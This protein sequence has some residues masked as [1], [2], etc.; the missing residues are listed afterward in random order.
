MRAGQRKLRFYAKVVGSHGQVPSLGTNMSWYLSCFGTRHNSPDKTRETANG[1]GEKWRYSSWWIEWKG[2]VDLR[3][4]WGFLEFWWTLMV[5]YLKYHF[6]SFCIISYFHKNHCLKIILDAFSCVCVCWPAL[7]LASSCCRLGLVCCP[8]LSSSLD[9]Q[10][11]EQTRPSQGDGR[12]RDD[13]VRPFMGILSL[14]LD[15]IC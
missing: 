14:C 13:K 8:S 4:Q 9:Q 2:W 1:D 3:N 5:F 15:H 10:A 12:H 7:A 11:T 6:L